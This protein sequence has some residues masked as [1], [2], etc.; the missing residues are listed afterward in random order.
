MRQTRDRGAED[1]RLGVVAMLLLARLASGDDPIQ[2]SGV[3]AIAGPAR[4]LNKE[5]EPQPPADSATAL[6]RRHL[7][8]IATGR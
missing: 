6:E 8:A 5:I 2:S 7:A 3:E 4:S 1:L